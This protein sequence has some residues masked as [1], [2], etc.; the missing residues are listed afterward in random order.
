MNRREFVESLGVATLANPSISMAA[1]SEFE[2]NLDDQ[3]VKLFQQWIAKPGIAAEN[4]GML[5]SYEFTMQP[6][7]DA[8]FTRVSKDIA[9]HRK[10]NRHLALG[11]RCKRRTT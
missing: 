7:R 11:I 2:S 3:T 1:K 9:R 4:S 5:E 10:G 8:G 6:L